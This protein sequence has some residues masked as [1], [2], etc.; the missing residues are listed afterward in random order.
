MQKILFIILTLIPLTSFSS[1]VGPRRQNHSDEGGQFYDGNAAREGM[2]NCL[3][4]GDRK[5]VM[6]GGNRFLRED[7]INEREPSSE[8]KK[9]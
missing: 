6:C 8:P 7:T 5:S 2:I 9:K 1:E 3:I 4:A